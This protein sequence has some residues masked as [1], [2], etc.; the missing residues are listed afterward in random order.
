MF[1][2]GVLLLALVGFILTSCQ[3]KESNRWQKGIVKD[4]FVFTKAPFKSCHASTIEESSEGLVAAWFAGD[5][6]GASNVDIWVSRKENGQWTAP[7]DVANGILSDTLRYPCWNPVLFQVPDGDLLLFYK[8]GHSPSTW[9]G[10]MKSSSD[11]GKTWSEAEKLPDG[12][13]GPIKNKPV[14]LDNGTLLCGS[15]TEDDGWKVHFEMTTDFGKTWEKTGDINDSGNFEIIQPTILFHQDGKLQAL[16]RSKNRT[17]AQSWS[18]DNGKTWSPVKK[19]SL[20]GNDSG[21]DAVTLS[22]GRQ[23]LVYNHVW[24]PKGKYKGERTPLNVAVSEDGKTWSATNVIEVPH[25]K[26]KNIDD[27]YSYPAVIQTKDGLVHIVYTWRRT[28]IKHV[29]I[30][31]SKMELSKMENG[32]WPE[33]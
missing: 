31:P 28:R 21:I 30:D 26:L 18:S 3:K 14:L 17:I 33:K 19:T 23:L 5:K 12:I 4:E 10:W 11:G 15:S 27:E 2:N 9:K 8:I 22:D 25:P 29:V 24:P 20:P 16:F 13:L 7:E 32:I 6:E 1:K